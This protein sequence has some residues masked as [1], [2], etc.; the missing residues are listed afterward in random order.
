[1][2]RHLAGPRSKE[3]KKG[4]AASGVD[5]FGKYQ[6]K[7]IG[8]QCKQKDSLLRR[9]L[10]TKELDDEVSAAL[11]F[12]PPLSKFVLATTGPRDQK[13]QEHALNLTREHTRTGLFEVEVW[14]WED[15]WGELYQRERL[16][17]RIAATYWPRLSSVVVPRRSL[18]DL[19]YFTSRLPPVNP[20]LIGREKQ[21]AALDRLW[22]DTAT[23]LVQIIASGGTGK[24]ALVAKWF[25]R[26]LNETGVFYWPFDNQ[27]TSSTPFF[28]ELLRYL[29]IKVEPSSSVYAKA[30]VVASRLR[31]ERLLL[32]LDGVESLQDSSGTLREEAEALKAL[33]QELNTANHGLAVCVT[34]VRIDIPDDPPRVRSVGLDDLTPEQGME[35]C[36]LL[37]WV[38]PTRNCKRHRWNMETTRWR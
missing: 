28:E 3:W 31:Q 24:T 16:L 37:M 30:E 22:A 26:H 21:L 38:A 27:G 7:L 9:V 1:M 10:T 33:L 12:N 25:L 20:N 8:V 13:V 18:N 5:I 36:V 4:P 6:G 35:I 15:I 23:N 2:A 19:R 32:I 17:G 11:Q 14:C 34:R 29:E